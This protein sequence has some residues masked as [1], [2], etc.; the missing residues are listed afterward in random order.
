MSY[1]QF[2]SL[3]GY[4]YPNTRAPMWSSLTQ[5]AISGRVGDFQQYVVPK[6]AYQLQYSVLRSDATILDF[7]TLVGFYNNV[8]ANGNIFT[9]TDPYDN[10]SAVQPIGTGDGATTDFQLIRSFGGFVEPV[11]VPTGTTH[12][13]LNGSPTLLFTLQPGGI[14]RLNSPPAGG[15]AITW[16]GTFD[17]LCRFTQDTYSFSN[18]S[19]NFW[20]LQKIEFETLLP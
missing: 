9:Y 12:V 4:T 5:D 8:K 2:P 7:Q 11:F 16:N 19:F 20:E 13:Q 6:W 3:R 1:L 14:V 15:V 10:T 17:W 18:F